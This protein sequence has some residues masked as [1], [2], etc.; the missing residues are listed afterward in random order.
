MTPPKILISAGEASSDMYAARLATALRQR[1][2]AEFFGMGGPRMKAAG[3]ELVADYHEVAVVGIAEV[4]HKIPTVISVQNR[5]GREAARRKAAL[6]ILVDSPGTHLGVARRLK[7]HGIPVGYFIG[8]QVWAW[9]PGR[10][11]VVKRLVNRMVVIFPFEEKIYR[12][13]GVPVDFVGHPLVDVVHPSMTR[14]EFAERCGLDAE[15]LIVTLLPG[16]RRNEIVQNW[17]RILGACEILAREIKP[18]HQLQFVHAAAPGLPAELFARNAELSD[19]TIHRVEGATYDALASADYAIVASGTAT[20]EAALLGT[21]MVVVYRVARSTAAVLRRMLRTPFISMTN[22]V[23]GRR[24]VPELIQDD[25]TAAAVAA[26]VRYLIESP[27]GRDAMKAGLAEVRAKLGP[28]RA[29]ERAADVFARM[30]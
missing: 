29:I 5:L 23:T 12:D 13:A 10:V 19:V 30:L 27:D 14:T 11:R 28:G 9:R 2:G 15:R 26:E 20:I 7:N 24:V 3:V 21:P 16:S 22:L 1:T 6:G 18:P 25:F 8:P 17:P 4:L